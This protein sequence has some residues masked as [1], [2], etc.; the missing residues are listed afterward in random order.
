MTHSPINS[1]TRSWSGGLAPPIKSRRGASCTRLPGRHG[2]VVES[3]PCRSEGAFRSLLVVVFLLLNRAVLLAGRHG[4]GGRVGRSGGELTAGVGREEGICGVKH[5]SI[6]PLARCWYCECATCRRP[7]GGVD[8]F[9]RRF[10]ALTRRSK[11]KDLLDILNVVLFTLH[12][13]IIDS[14]HLLK[15]KD[16]L[17]SEWVTY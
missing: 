8:G 13:I 9:Y 6:R 5:P 16:I 14:L 2:D 11:A 12:Q 3:E 1:N 10:K 4:T 7:G 17:Y 15:I